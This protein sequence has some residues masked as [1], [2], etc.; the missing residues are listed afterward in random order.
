[1]RFRPLILVSLVT[2]SAFA[3][4]SAQERPDRE[5]PGDRPP[6]GPRG[7][8]GP[9][10]ED[11]KLVEKFDKNDDGWLNRAERA[12]ARKALKAQE[13]ER[14]RGG[15]GG[16]GGGGRRGGNLPEASAGAKIAP[17]DVATFPEAPLYD[18]SVLRT[19]FLTFEN[20]DWEAELADFKR[21]DV[22]VPAEM[23]VDG[24][25]YAGVG[26]SF[27]GASSFSRIPAGH[28][29]SFNLSVDLVN[30][31]QRLY[32]Y[33]N[34]NLLNGSGDSSF[35]S[36]VLYSELA[37]EHI[38]APKANFVQ[39]VVNGESWGVYVNVQQFDK[40]FI[41][42]NFD[43][44]KGTR[45]KVPGSPRGDGGLAYDGDELEPYQQRYEMKSNDG[46]K[47]WKALIEF[48]RVLNET[49]LDQLEKEL[50]PLLD[51]DQTLRFLA[52]DIV[53]GNSD[54]YWARASDYYIFLDA[55]GRFH[56]IPHDM[57][58]AFRSGHRRESAGSQTD[59]LTGLDDARKPLR[60]RL[61]QVPALRERYLGYVREIAEKQLAA[62]SLAEKIARHRALIDEAVKND[63]RKLDSYESFRE[64]TEI[65]ASKAA[66]GSLLKFAQERRDFLLA[67]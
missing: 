49:P 30:E 22:E 6:G 1:M 63:T 60:S 32:G 47:A 9:N 18:P 58:E 26:V 67:K 12:E 4:A 29:R 55:K 44:S 34:L 35:M 5:P 38:A 57:N 39:V 40:T 21:S 15:R 16:R 46:K 37:R 31:D 11:L 10:R 33:K 61:L 24:K 54:G 66:Q 48:C 7:P 17:G 20:D 59:P 52:Y 51:I 45:W 42:E 23:T 56:I 62:D 43:P 13:N 2:F 8:G 41:K 36:T 64:S 53:L 25:T 65:E 27:R 14:P 3:S 19:I 28:K 50:S